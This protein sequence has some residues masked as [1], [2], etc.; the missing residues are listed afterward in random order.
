VSG[1]EM[2]PKKPTLPRVYIGN[3]IVI[4]I[5]TSYIYISGIKIGIRYVGRIVIELRSDVVPKTA[6]NFRAL[7][8]GEKGYGYEGNQL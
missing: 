2:A 5:K 4:F 1:E 6:E 8:T 7:C 3:K